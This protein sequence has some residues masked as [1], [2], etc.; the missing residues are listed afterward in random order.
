MLPRMQSVPTLFPAT[1]IFFFKRRLTDAE[2][3]T[4]SGQLKLLT[5][6]YAL[7]ELESKQGP[8]EQGT[9]IYWLSD[10]ENMVGLLRKGSL[11][12]HIQVLVL[13]VLALATQLKV[14]LV[15]IHLLR[16]DPRI[17]VADAGS[18]SCDS[19]D[20]SI[21][22]VS[23]Q[24][25]QEPQNPFTVDLFADKANARLEKFYSNY[26]VPQSAGV[27]ALIQDWSG[28][29]CWICPP[30]KLIIQSVEKIK[31]LRCSGC[32]EVT[33]WKT[34]NFWPFLFDCSAEVREPFKFAKKFHP[35]VTQNSGARSALRGRPKFD[36]LA[37]YFNNH[38]NSC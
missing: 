15:P 18:K 3:K 27:D 37:I 20:W 33:E 7:Q 16:D 29:K 4:S 38:Y 30:V 13:E 1:M 5:V 17:M 2:I 22:E 21:D 34:A 19:D 35:Y 31:R 14:S 32:L 28:E 8:F 23:F 9:T 24:E 12:A 36:M 11:K 25:L 6:K 10:S 26:F